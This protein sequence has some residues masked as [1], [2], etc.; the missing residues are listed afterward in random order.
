MLLYGTEACPTNAA[1]KHSLEFAINRWLFKI[2]G[3]AS[4][5]IYREI[6]NYFGID[7]IEKQIADRQSKFILRYSSENVLCQT[8]S[9]LYVM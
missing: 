7:A 9:K 8:I 2:F 3:A 1:V 6:F 4:K 5:E